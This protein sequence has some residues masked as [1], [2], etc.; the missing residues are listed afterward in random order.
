MLQKVRKSWWIR[1]FQSSGMQLDFASYRWIQKMT[2]LKT[3]HENI[4][5]NFRMA[6]L[7]PFPDCC[8]RFIEWLWKL[9]FSLFFAGDLCSGKMVSSSAA[10]LK[11]YVPLRPYSSCPEHFLKHPWDCRCQT[12][13]ESMVSP[14]SACWK[15]FSVAGRSL[16]WFTLR[17]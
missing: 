17:P 7:L 3:K 1:L 9:C 13:N 10:W 14:Y 6:K 4:L 11:S 8:G 2:Y 16:V 5:D 15:S 12:M